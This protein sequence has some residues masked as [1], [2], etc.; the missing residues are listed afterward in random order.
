MHAWQCQGRGRINRAE[1]S[2][3]HR[4]AHDRRVPLPRPRQV[5]DIL[6]APAQEPQILDPLDRAADEGI[7]V[8]H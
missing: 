3:R 4:A 7:D 5:I 2:V 8:S 1:I 6:A